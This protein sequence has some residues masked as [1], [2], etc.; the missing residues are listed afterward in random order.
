RKFFGRDFTDVDIASGG[1][2]RTFIAEVMPAYP[3][4]VPLLPEAAHQRGDVA[5]MVSSGSGEA[6]RCVLADLPAEA[7]DAAGAHGA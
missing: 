2:S 6:F 5:Y 7:A 4:Y 3:L 1:R